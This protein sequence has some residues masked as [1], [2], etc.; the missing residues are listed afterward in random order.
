M[1][2]HLDK[3]KPCIGSIIIIIIIIIIIQWR[4]SPLLGLG[5]LLQGFLILHL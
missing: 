2:V 1:Y 3:E 4:S 5:L